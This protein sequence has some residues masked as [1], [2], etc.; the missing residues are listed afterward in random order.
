[1]APAG[2]AAAPGEASS[3]E[4]SR[5]AAAGGKAPRNEESRAHLRAE[6]PAGG[7]KDAEIKSSINAREVTQ[8]P[9]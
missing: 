4:K 1:M 7:K 8:S 9:R 6:T 5:A 2:K 3:A